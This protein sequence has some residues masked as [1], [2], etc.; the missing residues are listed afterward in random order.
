MLEDSFIEIY[1]DILTPSEC[2][3]L[4]SEFESSNSLRPGLSS[5]GYD[6][7]IKKS[8]EIDDCRFSDGTLISDK[9]GRVLVPSVDQYN[10][11]YKALSQLSRWK[12]DDEYTFKKFETEDDGYKVWHTE[13]GPGE[14]CNRIFVWQIYLNNAL[15]GTEF[16]YYPIVE[17]R[18]GRGVIWPAGWTHVHRSALNKGIKYVLSGWISY[19]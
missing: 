1:D 7:R 12:I 9:I 4:I 5:Y 17:A 11:K 15:S 3:C 2:D 8:I 6:P 10:R 16:M 14:A 19:G 13:H 18:R